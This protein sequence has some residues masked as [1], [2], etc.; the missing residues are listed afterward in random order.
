MRNLSFGI[1]DVG[2]KAAFEAYTDWQCKIDDIRER[3]I[4]HATEIDELRCVKTL[5]T[6]ICNNITKFKGTN[7]LYV[8]W[9][10]LPQDQRPVTCD[11]LT[12]WG[13]S[14]AS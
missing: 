4:R 13:I 2:S 1:L 6:G 11:E 5:V 8:Q 9:N 3:S 12:T 10:Q 7:Y 14:A